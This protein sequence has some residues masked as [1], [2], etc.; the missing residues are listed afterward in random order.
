MRG[1]FRPHVFVEGTGALGLHDGKAR[2]TVEMRPSACISRKP[3]PNAETL[4]RL[5]PGRTIQSG[6]F[7]SRWSIISITMDFWPSMRKGLIE[8]SR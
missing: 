2:Q 5:P 4:P 7:Q 6:G 8:F 3:L 1:A